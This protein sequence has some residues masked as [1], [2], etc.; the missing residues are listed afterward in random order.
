MTSLPVLVEPPAAA[1][2]L[3][4]AKVHCRV[5]GDEEDALIE[6]LVAAATAHLDGR[7]G[8]LGRA[9]MPQRWRQT[10]SGPGPYRLSLPD[11]S[12]VVVEAD[13][14]V[15]GCAVTPEALGPLVSVDAE[16]S[17]AVVS[18]TCGLPAHL[19]PAARQAILMLAGHWYENREAVN[20]GNITSELP[21]AVA[22]LVSQLR[23]RKI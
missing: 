7:T 6:A 12:D 10:F 5:A 14:E 16:P 18:Y 17:Q 15:V 8:H 20:V 11:V 9:I 2:S 1:V 21:L 4:L 13:G 19:L 3:D 22:A 23:F